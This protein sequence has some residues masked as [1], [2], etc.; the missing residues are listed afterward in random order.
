MSRQVP[1]GRRPRHR[2]VTLIQTST[3][4][5]A[6]H[7]VTVQLM[8]HGGHQTVTIILQVTAGT[9]AVCLVA[10]GLVAAVL[11]GYMWLMSLVALF[12]VYVS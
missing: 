9:V 11:L 2:S 1:C 4:V 12:S 3:V 8:Q 5:V 7:V 10:V 6:D